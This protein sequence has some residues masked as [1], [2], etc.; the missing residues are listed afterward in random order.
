MIVDDVQI[1]LDILEAILAGRYGV[2]S[3]SSG[4]GARKML[5][6]G[7]LPDMVLLDI[8]MPDISGFEL[9][10]WMSADER[11]ANIPVIFVTGETDEYSEEKGLGM[12]AVDY[13]RKPYN[14]DIV[15]LK[16]NNHIELKSYRDDLEKAVALRTC[17][18]EQRTAELQMTFQAIILG[19]SLLSEMRDKVTGA[20]LARLHSQTLI[21]GTRLSKARPDV[22]DKKDA[23][24][25]ASYSPLHDV[26]KISVPDAV[27]NKAGGLTAEEFEIMKLHT[28][29]GGDVL[30]Q[31]AQF[32]PG[33]RSQL[34]CAIEIAECHHERYDGSG[35]PKKLRGAEIPLSARIV[36]LADVYDALRSPRPY[37]KGFSHE[38]AVKII[39]E[40]DGR[41]SP[42]HFDPMVLGAFLQE[43]AAMRGA[44]DRNPDP[45]V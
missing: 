42:A 43:E 3:A 21:I 22:M 39:T 11:L 14:A 37:K 9:L 25:I 13:I 36:S 23:E 40:G 17:E 45:H 34:N 7:P 5:A 31:I 30:R 12:G 8:S 1:N 4:E 41:T 29:G 6:S 28:K 44:Y 24:T 2:I 18:L 26:G 33:E 16:I 15:L 35:Y 38:E 20:H 19:M 10:A 27:L 32:L